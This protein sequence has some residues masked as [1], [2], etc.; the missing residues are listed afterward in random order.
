MIFI[1][2]PLFTYII[3]L[4]TNKKINIKQK[5]LLFDLLI[6]SSLYIS[7]QFNI[8]RY[9]VINFLMLNG[10]VIISYIRNRVLLANF[11]ALIIIFL[12]LN[13]FNYIYIMIAP[14]IFLI[15]FYKLKKKYNLKDFYFIDLFLEF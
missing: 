6:I 5:E 9:P 7:Y 12:Y 2:F 13:S 10:L 14:Y 15:I 11:M 3:F 8:D 4:A 1:L